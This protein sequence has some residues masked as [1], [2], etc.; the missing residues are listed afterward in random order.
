MPANMMVA[1]AG[2]SCFV[3][4]VRKYSWTE[5]AEIVLRQAD[6]AMSCTALAKEILRRGLRPKSGATPANSLNAALRWSIAHQT[7]KRFIEPSPGL[8]TIASRTRI[9]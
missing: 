9:P 6:A 7:P 2:S 3:L 8:Y 1:V 5:A 4:V